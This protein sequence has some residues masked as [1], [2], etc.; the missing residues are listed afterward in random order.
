MARLEAGFTFGTRHQ[1]VSALGILTSI[2]VIQ[3]DCILF[4]SSNLV[5][6]TFGF[7]NCFESLDSFTQVLADLAHQ[8]D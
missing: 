3:F 8:C 4:G 7:G 5:S 1:T 2:Y 6:H